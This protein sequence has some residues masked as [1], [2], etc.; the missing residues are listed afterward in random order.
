VNFSYT[1]ELEMA[2][3]HY[4]YFNNQRFLTTDIVWKWV[5]ETCLAFSYIVLLWIQVRLGNV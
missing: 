2:S 5:A 3:V 4:C 1:L